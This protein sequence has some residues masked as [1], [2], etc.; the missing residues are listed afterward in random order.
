MSKVLLTG[1]SGYI[2]SH[3]A[4]ELLDNNTDV[5]IV[6]NLSNSSQLVVDRIEE[7]TGKR[8][9]FYE[10]DI[11]DTDL[12]TDILKNEQIESVI[13]LAGLKSVSESQA[14]PIEYYDNNVGGSISLLKAMDQAKVKNIIFSS[15]ATV[16]GNPSTMPIDEST[17]KGHCT[18]PYGWSKSMVEEILMDIAKSDPTYKVV[19]LRYFNPV[20]AHKSGLIGEVPT[21]LPNNLAPYVA[22]VASGDLDHVRVFGDDY[23]TVDGTGVR[24]YIH[25]LD[26]ACGHVAALDHLDELSNLEIINL[27]TGKG[28]SVFD[29]IEAFKKVTGLDIAYEIEERRSGDVASSFCDPQKAKDLLDWQAAYD[30]EDMAADSWKFQQQNPRGYEKEK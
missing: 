26:L 8:V 11:R 28:Y 15:S 4:C 6:D 19:I 21:G 29:M 18:N 27:G 20:G 23:D 1:G 7:I 3:I 13:H 12:I 25:V 16:Y 17:P 30:L 10:G 22:R 5:V 9:K 2:G 24:D 14:H